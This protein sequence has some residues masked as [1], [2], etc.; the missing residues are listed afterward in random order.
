M[1][2][3]VESGGKRNGNATRSYSGKRLENEPHGDEII[4]LCRK[5][6]TLKKNEKEKGNCS[7]N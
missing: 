4:L 5:T 7:P 3:R 6:G 2:L 1:R